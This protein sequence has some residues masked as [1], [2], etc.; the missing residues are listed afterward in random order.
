[1]KTTPIIL[2]LLLL[3]G[4]TYSQ[5]ASWFTPKRTEIG[6]GEVRGARIVIADVNGDE[7]PD[8]LWGTG[9]THSNNYFLYLNQP[10]PVNAGERIFVDFTEESGINVNR[11]SDKEGRVIDIAG[12]ADLDNDG[13]PD[14]VTSIYYH[15]WSN[16]NGDNDP[17]DRSEVYLNDGSGRFAIV[18][19]NGLHDMVVVDTLPVGII[20]AT[21]IAFLDFNRDGFI[22]LYLST[23]FSDYASNLAGLGEYMMP[24]V[25][26]K[27]NGDGTFTRVN[28]PVIENIKR[29][30][31]GVNVTDWNNDGWQDVITSGYCRSGGTLFMNE[32]DGTFS[33]AS[34]ISNYSGQKMQGDGGQNLC[35]WEAIPADFDNDLDI[36]LLQVN[37]HG[38][39][40]DGEG[41]T[42]ITINTGPENGY[43]LEWELDRI[44]RDAPASSHLGDQGGMFFDMDYDGRLDIAI[45]QMAYPQANQ[46]GVERLYILKQNE[47]G[48]F[49]EVTF[50]L[51]L[52]RFTEAH[53]MEPC[54]YDLDGDL[55]LFFSHQVRD[56]GTTI[57]NYMTITLLEN[58]IGNKN[59]WI[60]IKYNTPD[61]SNRS[62]IGAKAILYSDGMAHLKEVQAASGHFSGQQH[63]VS[64]IGIGQRNRIDSIIVK[65]PSGGEKKLYNPPLNVIINVDEEGYKDYLRT[66]EDNKAV[67]AT[68]EPYFDFGTLDV[69]MGYEVAVSIKNI[70]DSPLM[71]NNVYPSSNNVYNY[72]GDTEFTLQPGESKEMHVDFVPEKRAFFKESLRIISNAHNAPNKGIDLEGFGF[73]PKPIIELAA[74]SISF[75][76]SWIGNSDILEIEITNSGE[77]PLIIQDVMGEEPF[78][79]INFE[80]FTLQSG[81]SGIVQIEFMP[82]EL[83][84]FEG[85][86]EI[87]SNAYNEPNAIVKV[88]GVSDGPAP[89]VRFLNSL[90]I[91]GTVGLNES[92]EIELKVVNE[93]NADLLITDLILHDFNDIYTFQGTE[94][95]IVINPDSTEAVL[96]NFSPVE[97]KDYNTQLT[98][99]TNAVNQPEKTLIVR[100]KGE[101]IN[102]VNEE[103]ELYGIL[104]MR[105]MPQPADNYLKINYSIN[106]VF[107]EKINLNLIDIGGKKHLALFSGL[108]AP[109]EN[110]E[111]AN[112]SKLSPGIYFIVA[113]MSYGMQAWPVIV[114]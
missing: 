86:V 70:G 29:P 75:E 36:D 49:N 25:L 107:P 79:S 53:S 30:M 91:F 52:E 11:D 68:V 43:K 57:E 28:S 82:V 24:D 35:Q 26:F 50:D 81:E 92:K 47:F 59:N 48:Y 109:G 100:G 71:V 55:D 101:V 65:W 18:P 2:C 54:D 15:R 93:G 40:H 39:Y 38:G 104:Q 66:W 58:D 22:D 32:G 16:Y 87:I 61:S 111:E 41:R 103:G 83:G 102:S 45:G 27:G 1:M 64:Y 21:G 88:R 13:D 8:L 113:K 90:L 14:L 5:T 33:N 17:G 12:F 96:I 78:N 99:K 72:T 20:N 73:E 42:H 4:I 63:F 95:P 10:H 112:I 34:L 84:T 76:N 69:G 6:L 23:W 19:D 110:N 31:Y 37:V 94:L 9:S 46:W 74:D 3:S 62:A 106:S 77:E 105:I 7:Y 44:E 60:G 98:V 85:V 80:Q 67:I 97:E 56:T 51:G 89:E 108:I 114:E